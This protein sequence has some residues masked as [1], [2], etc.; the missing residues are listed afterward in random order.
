M[1]PVRHGKIKKEA[2]Y[3]MRTLLLDI[4]VSFTTSAGQHS[5]PRLHGCRWC[6]KQP[7]CQ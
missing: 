3:T 5:R 2:A 4:P 7:I 1:T 6:G